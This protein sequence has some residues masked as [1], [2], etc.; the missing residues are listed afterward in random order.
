MRIIQANKFYFQKGGAERYLFDLSDWLAGQGHEVIPFTMRNPQNKATKYDTYFPSYVPT[1]ELV[2][3]KEALKTIGRMFYSREARR[4]MDALIWKTHP[5]ICHVHNLYTQ[6]SCSPLY[7]LR[8]AGIPIVMTVHDHHLISAE[9]NIPV[10][11]SGYK[12]SMGPVRAAFTRFHKDSFAASF[13]QTASF[14]FT[15]WL[16]AY[17]R[18]VDVFF[19]PSKYLAQQ[20]VAGGFPKEK[21][22]V[23]Y[24]GKEVSHIVPSYDHEGYLLFVGRLV[25]EKGI[26][27]LIR[28]AKDFPEIPLKIV[29]IGPDA[30]NMR[31]C[32][33]P[34]PHVMCLGEQTGENLDALYRGALALL[35][36]SAVQ[37][38]FPLVTLE[39]MQYG[40][41]II[42]SHVGGIPEIVLDRQTGFLVDPFDVGEWG[43]A[44]LRLVHD[45][46]LR[47]RMGQAARKRVEESF[48]AQDHFNRVMDVYQ[49]TLADY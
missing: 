24:Y 33:R 4:K 2:V 22:E 44:I 7:A 42:A 25:K 35:L 12:S 6:L 32:L 49:K 36:P 9:Y 45:E 27:M 26:E 30:Q 17:E 23:N 43:E 8:K 13:L 41:P 31:E 46:D 34:F 47:R 28:I 37:D 40:K 10:I 1:E 48:R 39:A 38:V 3:N 11:S 20:L 21:I 14:R 16:H 15:R 19:V 18:F 5:D 29:G